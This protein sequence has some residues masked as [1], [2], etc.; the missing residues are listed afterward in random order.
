MSTLLLTD[1]K[2]DKT[3]SEGDDDFDVVANYAWTTTPS[4]LR[5]NVPYINLREFEI[6]I[7]NLYAQLIYWYT[8]IKEIANNPAITSSSNP[9]ANLYHA[10]ETGVVYRLPYFETYD[11]LIT[12]T[13]EKTK[14]LMK[15]PIAEKILNLYSLAAKAFQLAPGTSVNQPQ[16]WSG[17]GLA[18]YTVRFVLFNTIQS[19]RNQYSAEII[20]N[21]KFKWRLEMSTLHDQRTAILSAPPAIFEVFIPGV[22]YSPAA[23]IS[24]LNV[25]NLGQINLLKNDITGKYENIPDAYEFV[26]QITEL[27]SE[28]RQILDD[29]IKTHGMNIRSTTDIPVNLTSVRQGYEILTGQLATGSHTNQPL[30]EATDQTPVNRSTT[31]LIK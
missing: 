14:G 18:S 19:G 9:Y 8:S 15:F 23:V 16:I 7:A 4:N 27:I 5:F 29:G 10:K 12:Q 2:N 6:D 13:W 26:I 28:S 22:R 20:R 17:V 30:E 1:L 24:Q 3:Y 11:H 21:Q 25:S 31:G